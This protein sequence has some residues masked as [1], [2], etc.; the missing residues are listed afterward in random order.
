MSLVGRRRK[1]A[2]YKRAYQHWKAGSN[3]GSDT[4]TRDLTSPEKLLS[5]LLV[6]L[7]PS[8]K[9]RVKERHRLRRT[10]SSK[11]K[12]VILPLRLIAVPSTRCQMTRFI[13]IR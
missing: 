4:L 2:C 9:S 11:N 8:S 7:R 6:T 3:Y 1:T 5:R 10:Q 13:G 12:K